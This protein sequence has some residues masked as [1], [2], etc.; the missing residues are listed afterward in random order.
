MRGIDSIAKAVTPRAAE[1]LDSFLVGQRLEKAD[2]D[3]PVAQLRP[4]RRRSACAPWRRDPRPTESPIAAPASRER[5]VRERGGR[6]RAL[7]DHDLDPLEL[8]HE[9]GH[10]GDS[11]L[12][13]RGLLRHANLH[14]ARTLRSGGNRAPS[15]KSRVRWEAW[16]HSRL[17][18]KLATRTR[19]AIR[20]ASRCSRRR[21]RAASASTRS[22]SPC[23]AS[24]RSLHDVGKLVVPSSVLLKRG[25]LTEEELGLMR[26]HPAAGARMLRSL[27]APE[28]IL[29]LVLHHHERWDGDGYPTGSPRRRHPARGA[30]P[31]ASRTR[32]TR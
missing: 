10:E 29:P 26:R 18:S 24:V 6:A 19:A 9:V 31:R 4:P 12:A 28:T 7:L 2:E 11:P 27:G 17:R 25:P 5:V 22:G 3:L 32:S 15:L 21:W 8:R 20:R 23:C 13:L 30:R 16:R 1:A 14:G